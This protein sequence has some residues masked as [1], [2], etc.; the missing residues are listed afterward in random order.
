MEFKDLVSVT[1]WC[2]TPFIAWRAYRLSWDT[3]QDELTAKRIEVLVALE[4]QIAHVANWAEREYTPESVDL[5]WWNP[6]WRVMNPSSERIDAFALVS[7]SE[8]YGVELV[9]ATSTLSASLRRFRDLMAAPQRYVLNAPDAAGRVATALDYGATSVGA[10][11][12]QKN[13]QRWPALLQ[14]DRDWADELYRLNQEAHVQGIGTAA[15]T[16]SLIATVAEARA[17]V[18]NA[19][20]SARSPRR[21]P[22][23]HVAIAESVT[24]IFL[25]IG[26]VSLVALLVHAWSTWVW[27]T[28]ERILHDPAWGRLL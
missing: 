23:L 9:A 13:P 20:S 17:R 26:I 15:T 5:N 2:L 27:P 7:D 4:G 11:V 25:V 14:G 21:L 10:R 8:Q 28:L 19:L 6:L 12:I 16:G 24:W 18:G 22:P 1:F 3:K